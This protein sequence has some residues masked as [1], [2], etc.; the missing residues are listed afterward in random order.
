[1]IDMVFLLLIFF[2]VASQ[3]VKVEKVPVEVPSAANSKVPEDETGRFA[4][5]VNEEER[6]FIGPGGAREVSIEELAREMA[7]QVAADPAIKVVI[8]ADKSVTYETTE[9]I[10]I[11][12]CA[13]AGVVDM[14]FAA[15]EK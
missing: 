2:L 4:I 11:D 1:M 5:T 12:A 6:I 14:I 15:F 9:K 10:M 7:V 3:I 8:R 13:E